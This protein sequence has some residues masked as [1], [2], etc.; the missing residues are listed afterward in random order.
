M[1]EWIP[2]VGEAVVQWTPDLVS[3]PFTDLSATLS[4]TQGSYTD[5]VHGSEDQCYYRV[6]IQSPAGMVLIPGGT[7][8][9]TNPL[10][11]GESYDQYYPATYSLSV[12]PFY[13]DATEVTKELWDEVY[14]WAT[15]NTYSFD[16]AGSGKASNHPVQTVNWYDCVKW[17]NA[18]SQLEGRTPCSTVGTNVYKTGYS[19]PDCNFNASGY[20][21]PT[22]A[23]WEYAA[24]GGY[25]SR[26]F[27][28]GDTIQHTKANY[29]STSSYSY[30]TSS[31]RGY[32]PSY[33]SGGSPYTSPVG[34]FSSNGFGLYDMSGNVREWCWDASG[35]GRG[36]RGGYP[37]RALSFL[38][39]APRMRVPCP[40]LLF[41]VAAAGAAPLLPIVS[42]PPG[43]AVPCPGCP[44]HLKSPWSGKSAPS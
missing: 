25:A 26:R 17:C 13:M 16:N 30:D 7:N 28:W 1:V 11:A 3:T 43:G 27:P 34:S 44:A 9:G 12:D 4:Y 32:H 14:N 39:P 5:T 15:N 31:T 36:F 2:A 24:R 38:N 40:H 42:P 23:E 21:L 41:P 35:L 33:T 22:S 37:S 8:S 20:R 29:E 19:E 18:R 6:E 10:A